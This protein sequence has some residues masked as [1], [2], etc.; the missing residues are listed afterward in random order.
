MDLWE[1]RE[2]SDPGPPGPEGKNGCAAYLEA[3]A[4]REVRSLSFGV[5]HEKVDGI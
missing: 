4:R 2:G 1:S 3:G 5:R